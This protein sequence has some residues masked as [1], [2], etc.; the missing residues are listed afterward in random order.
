MNF[1]IHPPKNQS[2][3]GSWECDFR[4]PSRY[5][6]TELP[7]AKLPEQES[8]G[9][10]GNFKQT[11]LPNINNLMHGTI[12]SLSA[13]DLSSSFEIGMITLGGTSYSMAKTDEENMYIA[14]DKSGGSGILLEYQTGSES[15]GVIAPTDQT[16]WDILQEE[17]GLTLSENKTSQTQFLNSMS[18]FLEKNTLCGQYTEIQTNYCS[19]IT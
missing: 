8:D 7:T 12:T 19:I 2:P 9:L 1:S 11:Y 18:I 17:S 13:D 15:I 3:T 5:N 6:K 10:S 16:I 4:P 14:L